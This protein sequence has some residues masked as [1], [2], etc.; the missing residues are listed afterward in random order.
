MSRVWRI[1]VR[2]LTVLSLSAFL[3]SCGGDGM[4]DLRQYVKKVK[5]RKPGRIEPLPEIKHPV[6]YF[7][8]GGFGAPHYNRE[9]TPWNHYWDQQG[10]QGKYFKYSSQSNIL[11]FHVQDNRVGVH[12]YSPYGELTDQIPDLLAEQKAVT[13]R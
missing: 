6:W 8:G 1:G 11:L 5:A 9:Q 13:Q 3:A 12:V 2:T 7:V 10:D 4:Q